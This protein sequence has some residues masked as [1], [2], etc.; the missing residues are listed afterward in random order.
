[1]DS[2]SIPIWIP[3]NY[4]CIS[5]NQQQNNTIEGSKTHNHKTN[6]KASFPHLYKL[7]SKLWE[8]E[9]ERKTTLGPIWE[10]SHYHSATKNLSISKDN[11]KILKM[12]TFMNPYMCFILWRRFLSLY[13]TTYNKRSKKDVILNKVN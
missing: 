11:I 4:K 5:R 3:L 7:R 13:T 6:I 1:M 12:S 8:E 2:N 9:R 10:L